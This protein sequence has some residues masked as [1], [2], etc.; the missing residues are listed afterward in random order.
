MQRHPNL[1]QRLRQASLQPKRAK[2]RQVHQVP[3]LLQPRLRPKHR[4]LQPVPRLLKRLLRQL[5]RKLQKPWRLLILRA[6]LLLPHLVVPA[7]PQPRP[8]KP[9]PVHLRHKPV[10]LLRRIRQ[11]LPAAPQAL[12]QRVQ[13]LQRL[14]R[15]PQPQR[16]QKRHQV[17]RLRTHQLLRQAHQLPQQV[18]LRTPQRVWRQMHLHQRELRK[19]VQTRPPVKQPKQSVRQLLQG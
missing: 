3:L 16:L 9:Q 17:R 11:R 7:Q 12:L 1:L 14:L 4:R 5:Q 8:R 10:P 18:R 19:P 15:L 13:V 6:C 2:L